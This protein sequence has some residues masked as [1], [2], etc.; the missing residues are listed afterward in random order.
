MV[1]KDQHKKLS[2]LLLETGKAHHRAF[3][4]TDGYDLEWPLWY[5]KY[6]QDKLPAVLG[7][8]LTIS[9]MVYCLVHLERE[10]SAVAPDT[11]W[12]DYY[13]D[14]FLENYPGS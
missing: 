3:I 13:A 7:R 10:Q 6:L 2:Q 9:E 4:E 14:Y 11:W 8:E 12:S 5:A 1:D